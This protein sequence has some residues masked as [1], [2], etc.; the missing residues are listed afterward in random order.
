MGF[1]GG[2]LGVSEQQVI[3]MISAA[4]PAPLTT[5]PGSETV[6]GGAGSPGIYAPGAHT[7]PRLTSTTMA[8]VTTGT[9][10]TAA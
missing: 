9:T 4:V 8:T 1:F 6:A 5:A 2:L 7:H 3:D 10:A